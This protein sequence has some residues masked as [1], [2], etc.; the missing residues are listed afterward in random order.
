MIGNAQ[1]E[2]RLITNSGNFLFCEEVLAKVRFEEDLFRLQASQRRL[3]KVERDLQPIQRDVSRIKAFFDEHGLESAYH[4]VVCRC[5]HAFMASPSYK[6]VSSI[7]AHHRAARSA[8][9]FHPVGAYNGDFDKHM[10][11]H[12]R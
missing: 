9:K 10:T 6:K 2:L 11:P 3:E 12:Q 5:R 7:V 4:D 1:E 8:A